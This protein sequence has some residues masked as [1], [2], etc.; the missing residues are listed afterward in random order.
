MFHHID[1]VHVLWKMSEFGS[2]DL[3]AATLFFS[4]HLSEHLCR[5][6]FSS[7]SHNLN[8]HF[9]YQ[10]YWFL[11]INRT[12]VSLIVCL[13]SQSVYFHHQSV[14]FFS[15]PCTLEPVF[16]FSFT[17]IRFINLSVISAS[18]RYF[19]HKYYFWDKC[20]FLKP[21]ARSDNNQL[22]WACSSSNYWSHSF[23]FLCLLIRRFPT[24]YLMFDPLE[25]G[26]Q[27]LAGLLT[28][29]EKS[30]TPKS[31]SFLLLR[32]M[33]YFRSVFGIQTDNFQ[34]CQ[35]RSACQHA[36]SLLGHDT[37]FIYKPTEIISRN[38]KTF[39]NFKNKKGLCTS[40][41]AVEILLSFRSREHLFTCR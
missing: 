33:N 7:F 15:L 37:E 19:I 23:M 10:L 39:F 14:P 41:C 13:N 26:K 4:V 35:V 22:F 18:S 34:L 36:L 38:Q 11:T 12:G 2:A 8:F 32:L 3:N 6:Q 17:S 27:R 21:S 5:R 31:L 20:H 16:Y 28:L 29:P 40:S 1:F 24:I 25:V 9:S 30:C